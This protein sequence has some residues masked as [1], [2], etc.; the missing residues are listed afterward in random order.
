MLTA[1]VTLA[2]LSET[3]PMEIPI[4]IVSYFPLSGDRIDRKVTGDCGDTYEA[5][6]AKTERVTQETIKVLEEGS[7][8]HGYKDPAAKPSLRYVIKGNF[9]FKEPLPLRA[10]KAGEEV[11]MTDYNSI[12]NRIGIKDW[13]EKKGIKEVWIWGYHGGVLGLWES[14]MSSPFG[15]I[16]NSNRD[17]NDL[18]VLKKTYTVYHYNYGRATGE[19]VENHTHQIEALLNYAD[20]RDVT[21]ESEWSKLLFWGR[22]VGSDASHK[23]VTKPAR[24]GWTHYAPNS[25]KDYDWRNPRYVETDIEDWHPDY[26]GRTQSINCDRWGGDN[27]KWK[28]YWMQNIPGANNGLTFKGKPLR[29]W[30]TFVGDWD[31]ARKEN[32]KLTLP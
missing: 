3:Q 19:T 13:V 29:N 30:W 4:V 27:V 10:K 14:N 7:R 32:W 28:T 26:I 31:R 25:E 5:T 16:S 6:K 1:L 11:P 23:I 2:V 12:M 21:P 8:Y 22:F 15:D 24:C 17:P 9:E 20:G 18:P